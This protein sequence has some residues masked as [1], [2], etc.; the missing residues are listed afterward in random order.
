MAAGRVAMTV[1]HAQDG[2]TSLATLFDQ[3]FDQLASG[4][5]DPGP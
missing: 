2:R 3:V 1:W 5:G 4:F